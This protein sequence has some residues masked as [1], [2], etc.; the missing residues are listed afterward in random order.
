MP[1]QRCLNRREFLERAAGTAALTV[2]AGCGDGQLSGPGSIRRLPGGPPPT[3]SV[4]V[5]D[6]PELVD[7]A[8]FHTLV[9][10][11]A[12]DSGSAVAVKRTAADT[13]VAMS[14]RCTHEGCPVDIVGGGQS[15]DCPCHDSHFSNDGVVTQGPAVLPLEVISTSYDPGT[16]RLTIG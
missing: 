6:F 11:T 7:P 12:A 13:F 10:V 9:R 14:M 2:L 4:L 1:C 15:F 8:P 16:G 3:F 5:A